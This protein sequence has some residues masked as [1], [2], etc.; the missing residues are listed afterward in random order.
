MAFPLSLCALFLLPALPDKER[1]RLERLAVEEGKP[2]HFFLHQVASE[3]VKP[4]EVGLE[5]DVDM[6]LQGGGQLRFW[7][8][9]KREGEVAMLLPLRKKRHRFI[10]K[11]YLDILRH[12][13][14]VRG[15]RLCGG[16][17]F[18]CGYLPN[19]ACFPPAMQKY[20]PEEGGDL[21]IFVSGVSEIATLAE[22]LAMYAQD[23]KKWIVLPL[24][25]GG[26]SKET[27][28]LLS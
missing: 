9:V 19:H 24:H 21:L 6:S 13:D 22:D 28:S 7:D 2:L 17:H 11:P 18:P 8:K 25:A 4:G 26:Y 3:G 12:I 16:G 27:Q 15:R 23:T 14:E 10:T 20:K 5:G 1:L